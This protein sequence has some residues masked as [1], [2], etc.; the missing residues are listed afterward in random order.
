MAQKMLGYINEQQ[1]IWSHIC[2]NRTEIVSS[3]SELLM[4]NKVKRVAMVSSG[5]SNFAARIAACLL[6]PIVAD[7]EWVTVVPTHLEEL[8]SHFS[9]TIVFAVSQSGKSTSTNQA[10]HV[11]Q[12]SGAKVVSITSDKGS[13][14]AKAGNLHVCIECGE[15]TVGPKTKGMT[16][17]VLTLYLLGLEIAKVSGIAP[18]DWF[19]DLNS[20][21]NS[22]QENIRRSLDFAYK[23]AALI[24]KAPCLTLIADGVGLP[25]SEEGALKLLETLYIP[26]S[27]WEFE[28]F[29]HGVNNIIGPGV[30]HIFLL[31][32]NENFVRMNKLI[33]YCDARG[34]EVFVINCSGQE[35]A[36]KNTITLVC[37]GKPDTLAY[38]ALIPYQVLSAVVSEEKNIQCDRPRYPDF[39]AALGTKTDAK[40]GD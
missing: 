34:C 3:F 6:R 20:A 9:D 5:S 1:S 32:N 28:E 31:Q 36:F 40:T 24:A 7:V 8:G 14:V 13:P 2:E 25:I 22:T 37:T 16:A 39:Y 33:E 27:A 21:F 12:M 15:E 30:C 17:T 18:K 19:T 23:N 11:L 29:L 38:E 35:I 4:N 10:I 26:A